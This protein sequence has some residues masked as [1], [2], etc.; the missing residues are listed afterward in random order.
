[1]LEHA[2]EYAY[3]LCVFTGPVLSDDDPPLRDA[4]IPAGFWKVVVLRDATAG[5]ADLSVVA[6]FMKQT[7]MLHDKLGK[8][9]LQLQRYQ[10]TLPAIEA[11]TGLDFGAL[12]NADELAWAPAALRADVPS[13][14]YRRLTGPQ[15]LVFSGERRRAVGRRILPG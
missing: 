9:L 15:D 10:V 2:S 13:E 7:E 6:F 5:G 14:S 8:K 12:K 3:R 4:Q 1:M 11:W